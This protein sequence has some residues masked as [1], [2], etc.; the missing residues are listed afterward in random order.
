MGALQ[1]FLQIATTCSAHLSITPLVLESEKREGLVEPFQLVLPDRRRRPQG[2]QPVGRRL[3][4]QQVLADRAGQ[5]L[6]PRQQIDFLAMQSLLM[7]RA[8]AAD[9]DRPMMRHETERERAFPLELF[10]GPQRGGDLPG[11]VVVIPPIRQKGVAQKLVHPSVVRLDHLLAM[12]QPAI[13]LFREFILRQRVAERGEPFQPADFESEIRDATATHGLAPQLLPDTY[14]RLRYAFALRK[15]APHLPKEHVL[16][17][18]DARDQVRCV[19]IGEWLRV[20]RRASDADLA[21]EDP[22]LSRSHFKLKRQGAHILLEDDGSKSGTLVNGE[23]TS[24]RELLDGDTIQAGKHV[25]VYFAKP[26]E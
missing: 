15:D 5:L 3:A 11:H 9:H 6:H 1:S 21:I 22:L 20:G 2:L 25:F 19:P 16:V 4:E 24:A 14:K 17:Y 8:G 26:E 13:H 23:K 7:E 12:Q 10:E 18:R